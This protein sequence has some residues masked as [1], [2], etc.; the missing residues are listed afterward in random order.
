MTNWL[1]SSNSKY[2]TKHPVNG[3]TTT[4]KILGIGRFYSISKPT[5]EKY[6]KSFRYFVVP[7]EKMLK[8][9]RKTYRWNRYTKIWYGKI[10]KFISVCRQERK[11]SPKPTGLLLQHVT[12]VR[13]HT[14]HTPFFFFF[15]FFRW[16]RPRWVK[17]GV[18]IAIMGVVWMKN[19][20]THTKQTRF[21]TIHKDIRQ[22]YKITEI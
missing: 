13:F 17:I 19:V 6:R 9:S 18:L 20:L 8:I 7:R 21:E 4:H 16:G 11:I 10:C 3:Y 14:M 12:Q 2:R 22:Q 5:G 15:F 1:R